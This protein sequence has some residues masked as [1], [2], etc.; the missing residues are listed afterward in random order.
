MCRNRITT[1]FCLTYRFVGITLGKY[2]FR[3]VRQVMKPAIRSMSIVFLTLVFSSGLMAQAADDICTGFGIRPS[4][5]EPGVKISYIYGRIVAR[6]YDPALKSPRIT[7]IFLDAQQTHGR[8]PI[9]KS[10]NYCFRRSASG[11][12]TIIIEVDGIETARKSIS[13]LSATRQRED[14]EISLPQTQPLGAPGVV[15]VKFS[16]PRNEKTVDLYQKA[17]EAESSGNAEK[18]VKYV[19]EIVEIDAEDFIA[20]AKLGSLHFESNALA[21][22]EAAFR[23]AIEL[24]PEYTPALLNL[25]TLLAVRKDFEAAIDI[26]KKAVTDDPS[27]GRGFR[28]L[29]EAYLQVRKGTLGLEAL[30]ESLRLDPVGMAECHLLIARLYDLAG[31]KNLAAAEY[32]EFLKKVPKHPDKK[33]FEQYIRD[34]PEE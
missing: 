31:A 26:L 24:K 13:S 27:S 29:G 34:N 5:D 30:N 10:G 15:S 7:V 25:G 6:G 19:K 16:R 18:A 21:D 17:A 2:P 12:G 3:A 23:K 28:L 9:D 1:P 33:K 32:R 4:F 11:G 14:F 20:W 22:A 8:L